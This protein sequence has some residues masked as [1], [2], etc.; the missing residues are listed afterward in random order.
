MFLLTVVRCMKG[1]M[2]TIYPVNT[3]APGNAILNRIGFSYM[4]YGMIS[5]Y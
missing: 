1:I 5:L 3:K 4:K 2:I